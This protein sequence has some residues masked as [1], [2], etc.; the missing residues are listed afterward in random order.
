M[1]EL[2]CKQLF[3]SD[4]TEAERGRGGHFFLQTEQFQGLGR[5]IKAISF[6]FRN[7]NGGAGLGERKPLQAFPLGGR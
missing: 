1:S 2:N 5:G 4:I 3:D 6:S 7:E